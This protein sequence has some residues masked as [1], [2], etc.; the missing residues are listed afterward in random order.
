MSATR[1]ANFLLTD[2]T[3]AGSPLTARHMLRK[4]NDYRWIDDELRRDVRS[5]TYDDG[6]GTLTIP[7]NCVLLMIGNT[8]E[9]ADAVAAATRRG[10]RIIET[11]D[12]SPLI[13]Y[14]IRIKVSSWSTQ[15]DSLLAFA[16][17]AYWNHTEVRDYA[18]DWSTPDSAHGTKFN[19]VSTLDENQAA[20]GTSLPGII[21]EC[22][23]QGN[24]INA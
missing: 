18:N 17:Q 16:S 23:A 3:R 14:F 11:S 21:R 12:R 22:K 24:E 5:A 9:L 20:K 19:Y 2:D 1:E 8:D 15:R 4:E 13:C 10:L 7:P 6:S